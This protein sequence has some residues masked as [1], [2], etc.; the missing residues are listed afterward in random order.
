MTSTALSRKNACVV[1][2]A[3]SYARNG[4]CGVVRVGCLV[5]SPYSKRGISK[6]FHSH[7]SLWSPLPQQAL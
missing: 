7:V 5:I 2:M 1:F 6:A 3:V 4:S